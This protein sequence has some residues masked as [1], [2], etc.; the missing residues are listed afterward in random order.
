MAPGY[1]QAVE[2]IGSSGISEYA[3][4]DFGCDGQ[5]SGN[6]IDMWWYVFSPASGNTLMCLQ[7]N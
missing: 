3:A 7:H 4:E 2:V 6:K 1:G 5:G